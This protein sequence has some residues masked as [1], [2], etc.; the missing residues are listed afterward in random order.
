MISQFGEWMGSEF[1]IP[2]NSFN[3]AKSGNDGGNWPDLSS[4]FSSLPSQSKVGIED[5]NCYFLSRPTVS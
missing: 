5:S 2:S 3:F 1:E 4:P